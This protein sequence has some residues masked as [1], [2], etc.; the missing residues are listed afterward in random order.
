MAVPWNPETILW[1]MLGAITNI[2]Q[3]LHFPKHQI[4]AAGD[5][6]IMRFNE[7]QSRS[8]N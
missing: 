4:D 7:A 1:S 2:Y 3:G 5:D 8:I 6:M